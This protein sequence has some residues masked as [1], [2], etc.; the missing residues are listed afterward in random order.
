M[1]EK[2]KVL[3]VDDD[4]NFCNTLS[5]VLAKKGYEISTSNSG[6][7]AMDLVKKS[8]VDMVLMDIKILEKSEMEHAKASKVLLNLEIKKI[9]TQLPGKQFIRKT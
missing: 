4:V 7:G 5:K 6:A 9:I 8:P 2:T 3:I 1:T